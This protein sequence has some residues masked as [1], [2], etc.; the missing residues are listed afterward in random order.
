MANE[1]NKL[2]VDI[3]ISTYT[4][5]GTGGTREWY[6]M[7]P[8]GDVWYLENAYIYTDTDK[9]ASTTNCCIWYLYDADGNAIAS[10]SGAA[11]ISCQGTAFASFDS[12]Y[13]RIDA[14]SAEKPFYL[15]FANS[16]IGETA[17]TGVHVV[18]RWSALR[19]GSAATRDET[20]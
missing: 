11:A 12:A 9:A 20:Y 16:G 14:A 15:A 3:P 6:G 13:R 10:V 5:A 1:S 4:T 2:I 17:M 7:L 8:Q 19:P 18:T